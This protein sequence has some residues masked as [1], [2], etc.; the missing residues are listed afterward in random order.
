M[1]VEVE[2]RVGPTRW[3]AITQSIG[4]AILD[5]A[6]DRLGGGRIQRRGEASA[7]CSSAPA[8][9]EPWPT[10]SRHAHS[11]AFDGVSGI[12]DTHTSW[13][14]RSAGAGSSTGA[15]LRVL[16]PIGR[17]AFGEVY[18]AWD[19][20][21]ARE[22]ALKLLPATGRTVPAGHSIIDEGR[23]LARVRHPNVVTIYGAERI[24]E[25]V[26]L[27]MEFVRGRTLEQMLEEGRR[28]R[29]A[30]VVKIGVQFV[31]AIGAVHARGP[32]SP[33]HQGHNVMLAEDRRVVLMDFGSGH[34]LGDQRSAE[35]AGTPL[36]LAPE[37][38]RG[39]SHGSQRRHTVL[40]CCSTVC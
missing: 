6:R 38:L 2:L 16:E 12:D 28:F 39:R 30:E 32:R 27:W 26:G 31:G 20:R 17:G 23:L 35:L 13:L 21:L 24:D 5:G 29:A 1:S 4:G 18:R 9:R 25:S 3:Q 7:N 40:A 14:R 19:T 33:R 36:Y 10:S 15:T 11:L 22:V 34:E 8:G 37:L